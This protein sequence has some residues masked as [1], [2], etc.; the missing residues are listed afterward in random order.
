MCYSHS[1]KDKL[2][3]WQNKAETKSQTDKGYHYSSWPNGLFYNILW[4]VSFFGRLQHE[5][6]FICGCYGRCVIRFLKR[7]QKKMQ[8][9]RKDFVSI[10]CF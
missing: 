8:S 4:C 9:L 7:E 2:L 3:K 1:D 6:D 10:S 5:A